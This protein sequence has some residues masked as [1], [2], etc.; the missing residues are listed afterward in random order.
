MKNT[1]LFSHIIYEVIDSE[2]QKYASTSV[3]G[4]DRLTPAQS[5]TTIHSDQG[6]WR[7]EKRKN[8]NLKISILPSDRDI[9]WLVFGIM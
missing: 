6:M 5:T 1:N 2:T 9:S 8:L 4:G 3:H 7:R